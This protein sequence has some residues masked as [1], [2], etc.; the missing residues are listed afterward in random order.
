MD[1]MGALVILD[2]VASSS[3]QRRTSAPAPMKSRVELRAVGAVMVA[4]KV[5]A[6]AIAVV[7]VTVAGAFGV[8]SDSAAGPPERSY[9]VVDGKVDR[10]TYNGYRRYHAGCNHCHGP[11]GLGTT[12]GPSLVAAA[13]DYEEFRLIVLNGQSDGDSVMRGFAGDGNVE[14]YI[15]DIY[16]YLQA[17][18]DGALGRG[19]PARFE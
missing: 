6:I 8:E 10:G 1:R 18:A 14:P 4:A 16:A 11:D 17:R 13:L 15:G 19:R 12:F 5:V 9:R 3:S 7:A 2:L